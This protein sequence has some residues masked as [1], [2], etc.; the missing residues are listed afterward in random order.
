[1]DQVG[2]LNGAVLHDLGIQHHHNQWTSV[3]GSKTANQ[4]GSYRLQPSIGSSYITTTARGVDLSAANS[5]IFP[6]SRWG[7]NGWTDA[8][9]R[10]WLDGGWGLHTTGTQGN[11]Y[12]NDLWS[13]TRSSTSGNQ[14]GVDGP[15]TRP[16]GPYVIWTPGR[17][18]GDDLERRAGPV[19][20]LVGG[21][22]YDSTSTNGNG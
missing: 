1:V 14:N 13:Y 20:W 2:T 15:E 11:G 8:A 9:G 19:L 18:Q 5:A 4:D 22:G 6:G 16:Y 21:Q 10:L 17:Q 7:A 12:L 3:L